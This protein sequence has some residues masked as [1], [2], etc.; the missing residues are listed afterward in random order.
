M[1]SPSIVPYLLPA[2]PIVIVGH[3]DHGKSTF[4][5]RLLYDTGS[6]PAE[7]IAQIKASSEKRGLKIEWSFLLDSLQ[8]ERDQG[9]T[10]DSTR[11]PFHLKNG[12]EFV[13][14]DA[15]GHRQFLRNMITGAADADA[16]ILVVDA[17]EGAK[18]QTRRHAMLLHLMGIRHVIVLLNKI[19]LLAFDEG[20]IRQAEKDIHS[21]LK[22]MEITPSLFVPVSARD[23]DNITVPSPNMAWYQGPTLVEALEKV[24]SPSSQAELPFR[25]PVQDVY[26]FDGTKRIVAG[27][28]ERGR[29]KVGD[30]VIIGVQGAKARIASIESWHTA[31]Q[32]SAVAGQSIA[33][34]L[35]PD[36]IP[37]RGDFLFPPQ[38][39][40]L[41]AARIKSRL[42]W[43]RQE[44]LKV[45]ESFLLRLATAEH[46]VTVASID[47]VYDLETLTSAS[48]TEVPPEGVAEITLAA[49]ENILFDAF[50][51]GTTDGRGVLVDSFQRIVGG[52]PLIGPA[53]LQK[54][55][56]AIHPASSIVS[57]HDRASRNG[58]KAGIFWLTGL[59]G[60]GKSTIA[61]ATEARLFQ[62]GIN[63][64]LIDGDTLRSGLCS[65]LGFS[66]QD[67]A[68][69]IRRAAYVARLAAESGLVV[70][71]S[72]IS[73]LAVER[74]KAKQIG[75]E[76]FQDIYI[77]TPLSVCEQRDPKGL[78]AQ[79]RSG[80]LKS[81][82]GID[83]PYEAPTSPSL[84]LS[85][86]GHSAEENAQTLTDYII[87]QILTKKQ[88]GVG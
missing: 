67:R 5:G 9:V 25:F 84:T 35:E 40:P 77:S 61:R 82:T 87:G 88:E 11:I 54:G 70:I 1:S 53:E 19:D 71:V 78:Y 62:E 80:K 10:V 64:L 43:L 4:I 50:S 3:V 56:Q 6:L 81:F 23:G 75:G 51:P 57:P 8:I 65:D 46:H 68:E 79:A 60:S 63:T 52:A 86:D 42:F 72:L 74:A 59:S 26:R 36:V 14:V 12:R 48:S 16:A 83:S 55:E 7:K 47:S 38:N 31:P 34:V 73:P 39:P 22:R 49:S 33:V 17:S 45:G 13:I 76:F 20:K 37:E 15:P 27:R 58:Y 30:E 69:N 18:E 24:P 28:L 2:T 21:L 41:K 29:I 85:T 44:P 66:E 32:I